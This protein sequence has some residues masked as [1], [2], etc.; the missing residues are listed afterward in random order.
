MINNKAPITSKLDSDFIP[1]FG[2]LDPFSLSASL[3]TVTPTG[4]AVSPALISK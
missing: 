2:R 4:F 3:V 1:V